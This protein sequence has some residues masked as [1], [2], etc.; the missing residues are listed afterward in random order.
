MT[1]QNSIL[2][3]DNYRKNSYSCQYLVIGTGAGG[4]VAGALLAEEGH[5]VIF[6]EEGGYY[7][8]E[9]Y[10]ANI[11]EMTSQLYRN[12]G[13]FPFLGKPTIA[14]AEGCCVGGGTVINGG[15]VW[16]T[17]SWILEEW[18]SDYGLEGYGTKDLTTYF[19]TVEKDMHVIRCEPEEEENLDSRKLIK[20]SEE[21]GWKYVMVPRA[22]KNCTNENLC[23]TGCPSGAK[24]STLENYI[25]RALKHGARI[26]SRC[27]AIKIIHRN[28]KAKKIVA[29]VIGNESK[30]I[31]IF[32]DHLVLA[33]GA[34]QTPHLMKRSGIS[35]IAG[36]KLQFHMNLKIVARFKDRIDAEKGTI[37][38]VQVQE[39]EREGLLITPSNMRPHYIVMALSH[40]GNDV[41]NSVLDTYQNMGIFALMIRSKSIAHITSRLGDQP[42]VSYKF[43][44][45]DL[46]KIKIALRR[47]A[48]ILFEAGALE[49]YLP[50]VGLET[51]TSLS[52]LDKKLE[53][54]NPRALQII[55]VHVM[56]SCPM[57]PD[58]DASV[59]N[60]DGA[61]WNMKN[62]L[63]T[64]ASVLPSNIGTSPQGTIMAFAHEIIHRH[65][66]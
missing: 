36:R 54:V 3:P 47:T 5:D 50:I 28:G 57:G 1:M 41:I 19:E 12:Q 40:Y 14:F 58:S 27:R 24:Q 13:V 30:Q 60:P 59:V 32:F 25:P 26:F 37:F 15:L 44:P 11:S 39:F 22:V 52:Q 35:D 10:N 42:L 23:P 18:Q 48:K 9:S 53:G 17:P 66:K 34:V 56:A 7:P 16:R 62:I 6:L 20:A 33:G 38:T 45:D 61:L 46:A 65:I 55:T 63:L 8:T 21:L 2:M 29:R 4:S 51:I 64:D 43:A 31:E 49:L